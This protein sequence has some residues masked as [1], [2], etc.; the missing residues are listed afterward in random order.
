MKI[1]KYQMK[2]AVCF[3][4][5]FLFLGCAGKR[6][7]VVG[8]GVLGECPQTPNCVSSLADTSDTIHAIAP[9]RYEGDKEQA[10]AKLITILDSLPRTMICAQTN[11]YLYVEFTSLI[12]RFVDDVEFVFD[13]ANKLINFRSASRL[14]KGDFGVNRARM[15]KIRKLYNADPAENAQPEFLDDNDAVP[16][17]METEQDSAEEADIE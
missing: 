6:P 1:R 8:E 10:M 2:P 3:L 7:K 5:A 15:E 4:A 9:L 14:G 17:G 11:K 12:W 16:G 13:E